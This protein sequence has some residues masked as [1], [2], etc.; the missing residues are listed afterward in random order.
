MRL[1]QCLL[2]I[3]GIVTAA[4]VHAEGAESTDLPAREVVAAWIVTDL[5]VRNADLERSIAGHEAEMLRVSP[6]EWTVNLSKQRRS[7]V[8]APRS[9][10][11]NVGLE[12]TI[13]LPGKRQLDTALG[14]RGIERAE[15]QY[16]SDS[17][18]ALSDL[19]GLWFDWIRSA[20]IA[21]LARD[22]VTLATSNRSTVEKRVKAGDAARLELNLADADRASAEQLAAEAETEA[23]IARTRLEA[24]FPK[25]P[26]RL[27]DLSTPI[28]E[29]EAPGARVDRWLAGSAAVRALNAN[30]AEAEAAVS[31]E[32]ADRLPDPTLGV[33]RAA[34][35]YGDERIV[36]ISV[37]IPLPGAYRNARYSRAIAE[38]DRRDT[39]I[40]L[41]LRELRVT[42]TERDNADR[43]GATRWRLARE[44]AD[45]ASE[46]VRLSQR[47]YALGEADLQTLL[48]ARRAALEAERGAIEAQTQALTAHYRFEI[49]AG[50]LWAELGP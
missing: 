14:A 48:I 9:Q 36:G 18:Q 30:R 15:A 34:E 24:R 7:Y 6:N 31:K 32:R 16:R 44:A 21:A 28:D 41:A 5:A 38:R 4:A 12:R 11:W 37:S 22:Q 45:R 50:G 2:L 17:R 8:D 29:A 27:P 19:V 25:A 20:R 1:I 35:A 40:E 3:A 26:T 46:N 49:E 13:R 23:T 39:E 42:A 33:F 10:E 47:A 43:G